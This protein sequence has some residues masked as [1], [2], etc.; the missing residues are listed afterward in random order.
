[1]SSVLPMN[2]NGFCKVADGNSVP[3]LRTTPILLILL[4]GCPTGRSQ[5]QQ[6]FIQKK[7]IDANPQNSILI[8]PGS[9]GSLGN[10]HLAEHVL[11]RKERT[12]FLLNFRFIGK[13]QSRLDVISLH[14]PIDP[15]CPSPRVR[16]R[17]EPRR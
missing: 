13:D 10:K 12:N 4:D 9:P 3:A 11:H 5:I 8:Q 16:L 14:S 1:M 2:K 17:T 7:I 15:D 6:I